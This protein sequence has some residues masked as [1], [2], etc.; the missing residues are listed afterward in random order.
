[1]HKIY[2]AI[3]GIRD[4]MNEIET[5]VLEIDNDDAPINKKALDVIYSKLD[6]GLKNLVAM[7]RETGKVAKKLAGR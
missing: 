6:K 5:D 1:M 7:Q 2:K 3:D 4:I